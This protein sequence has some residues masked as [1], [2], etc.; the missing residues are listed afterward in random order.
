MASTKI[1]LR[2]SQREIDYLLRCSEKVYYVAPEEPEGLLLTN[3]TH[4]MLLEVR[5]VGRWMQLWAVFGV[6][7]AYSTEND[8]EEAYL[9]GPWNVFTQFYLRGHSGVSLQVLHRAYNQKRRCL[10]IYA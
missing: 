4:C 9:V 1:R 7:M 6:D 2:F 5:K 3:E 10:V 8:G